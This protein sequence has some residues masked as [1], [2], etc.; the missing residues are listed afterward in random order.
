MAAKAP[1]PP[2]AYKTD[3]GNVIGAPHIRQ[4]R[5]PPPEVHPYRA[6]PPVEFCRGTGPSQA[7]NSRPLQTCLDLQQLRRLQ[8]RRLGPAH[9]LEATSAGVVRSRTALKPRHELQKFFSRERLDHH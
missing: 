8:W 3:D 7:A 1:F 2:F 4:T 9:T 6:L 5:Y